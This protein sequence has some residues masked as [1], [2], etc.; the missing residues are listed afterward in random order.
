MDIRGRREDFPFVFARVKINEKLS[1][2]NNQHQVPPKIFD[3][4]ICLLIKET[5][6]PQV[7]F[8]F[9]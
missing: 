6:I 8:N 5:P 7:F 4:K 9:S 2:L 3:R 1:Q